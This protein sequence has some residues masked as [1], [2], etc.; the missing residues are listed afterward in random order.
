[1]CRAVL[2]D[3]TLTLFLLSFWFTDLTFF[4]QFSRQSELLAQNKQFVEDMNMMMQLLNLWR[5]Q[6]KQ[7]K[8]KGC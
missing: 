2:T 6:K 3:Q 7:K 8:L 5:I 1:M 4:S